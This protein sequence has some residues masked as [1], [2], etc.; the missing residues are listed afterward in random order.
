MRR[1]RGGLVVLLVGRQ[2]RARVGRV[3][4][5]GG[6]WRGARAGGRAGGRARADAAAEARDPSAAA[7]SPE[8]QLLLAYVTFLLRITRQVCSINPE[9][10]SSGSEHQTFDEVH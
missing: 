6:Y 7:D 1:Q 4:R 5:A 3:E 9:L 8:L 2:R 10:N